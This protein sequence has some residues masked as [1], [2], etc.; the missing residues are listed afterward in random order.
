MERDFLLYACALNRI[1]AYNCRLSR[2]LVDSFEHIGDIFSLSEGQLRELMP[3]GENYIREILNPNSLEW[4][5]KEIAWARQYAV[6]LLYLYDDQYPYRLRECPDAPLMLYYIGNAN[7]NMQKVLSIVGTRRASPYG[8]E[9]C[10]K[11]V[12]QISL[13][14]EKTLI[15]SGLA[16]GID[17]VAHKSAIEFG[18][19]TIAVLPTGADSIYPSMHRGLAM[20]IIDNGGLISDF[21]TLTGAQK[22]NFV[23]RNR[24]IAGMADATLLAESFAHGGGLITTAHASSYS[25]EVFAV[26][27]RLTDSSFA[28]CNKIIA[29]NVANIVTAPESIERVMCWFPVHKA[30]RQAS[31]FKDEYNQEKKAIIKALGRSPMNIEEIL[32]ITNIP[33]SELNVNLVEL[34]MDGV[35]SVSG[36]NNYTL[37]D[38]M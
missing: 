34:E 32:T 35:I 28:G 3:R 29:S 23:R 16:F 14:E 4:A 10:R 33:V 24:I 20:Q 9:S 19:P 37:L 22:A 30:P 12:E 7:L 27:G 8:K 38:F 1:L 15:V 21:P 36:G 11:I 31:L 2:Q 17:A 6:Q 26:P 18:L 5:F 25:R 13:N